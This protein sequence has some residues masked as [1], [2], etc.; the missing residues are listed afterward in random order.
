MVRLG[1]MQD[2]QLFAFI[3]DSCP[4]HFLDVAS[5]TVSLSSR[6][7]N[8]S[9]RIWP[10]FPA[11]S[12]FSHSLATVISIN[13]AKSLCYT[14]LTAVLETNTQT[15]IRARYCVQLVTP[16]RTA[17]PTVVLNRVYS[18]RTI[19]HEN[20][21]SDWSAHTFYA[22]VNW[23]MPLFR[24]ARSDF[25]FFSFFIFFPRTYQWNNDTFLSMHQRR[26]NISG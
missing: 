24:V 9:S 6:C 16:N 1:S 8:I 10:P 23:N 21:A 25:R 22:H 5:S 17:V 15:K 11:C 13:S 2:E 14:V 18:S 3:E 12:I 19:L 7:F 20:L 26:R 4:S